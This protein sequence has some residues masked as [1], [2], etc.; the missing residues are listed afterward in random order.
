[1]RQ[2]RIVGYRGQRMKVLAA[3]D[4]LG[5]LDL[6]N[7]LLTP[8]GFALET[9]QNGTICLERAGAN[10]PDLALLD[11]TMPDMNGWEVAR[12]LRERTQAIP[13]IIVSANAD[14]QMQTHA[15]EDT[16]FVTKPIEVNHLLASIRDALGLDWVYDAESAPKLG[17][18]IPLPMQHLADLHRLGKIGYVR[19]IEAKLDEITGTSPEHSSIIA[20]LRGL[21]RNFELKQYMAR[22]ENLLERAAS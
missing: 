12:R 14:E 3:D 10:P 17:D 9:A 18:S 2:R 1:V 7:E 21:V 19:G 5:H 6:L 8:L 4:D 22:L 16:T 11:L 20:E 15:F 13:I